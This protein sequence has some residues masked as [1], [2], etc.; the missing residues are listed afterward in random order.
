[1]VFSIFNDLQLP[2]HYLGLGEDIDDM[3]LFTPEFFVD[4]LFDDEDED[5][6]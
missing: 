6:V 4:S 2:V 1:M 5:V 3:V